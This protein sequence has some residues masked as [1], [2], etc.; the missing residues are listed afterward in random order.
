M[1]HLIGYAIVLCSA[2]SVLTALYVAF[3]GPLRKTPGPPLRALSNIPM[4]FKTWKGIEDRDR[5]RLHAKYGFVVRVAP[6]AIS[7]NDARAW[8]DI[9]GFRKDGQ[10]V[11]FKDTEFYYTPFNGVHSLLTAD[12]E[13]HSRQRRV[14]SHSFADRTLKDLEP[15]LKSW[16]TKMQEKLRE[17][18]EAREKVDVLKFFNCW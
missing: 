6:K 17:R 8:K 10:S 11:P 18:A 4:A 5:V 3:L 7:Y 2:Y 15:L 12:N 13:G 9:Y 16:V 14:M 1:T